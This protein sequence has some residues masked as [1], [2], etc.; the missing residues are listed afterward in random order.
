MADTGTP[1]GTR[2]KSVTALIMLFIGDVRL[3]IILI[4]FFR[5]ALYTNVKNNWKSLR[6]EKRFRPRFNEASMV[7]LFGEGWAHQR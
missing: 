5:I 7:A 4:D 6:R 1:T 2:P 3:V